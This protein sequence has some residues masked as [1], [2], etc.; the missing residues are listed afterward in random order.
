MRF[1]KIFFV[2]FSDISGGKKNKNICVIEVKLY[3]YS[4]EDRCIEKS[5]GVFKKTSQI[6][7]V[8]LNKIYSSNF[9]LF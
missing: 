5:H 7:Y 4:R 1:T 8:N 3:K 2:D 9:H 6:C